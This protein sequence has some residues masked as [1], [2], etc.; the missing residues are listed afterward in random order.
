MR[1][2]ARSYLRTPLFYSPYPFCL[3]VARATVA[4]ELLTGTSKNHWEKEVDVDEE[5][6]FG[7]VWGW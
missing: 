3:S 1:G 4:R 5:V 6:D 2:S 7:T